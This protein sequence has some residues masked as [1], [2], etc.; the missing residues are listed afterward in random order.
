[1]FYTSYLVFNLE[2]Q[3]D[4]VLCY[5]VMTVQVLSI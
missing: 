5:V 4:I 3:I 2:S 1:M